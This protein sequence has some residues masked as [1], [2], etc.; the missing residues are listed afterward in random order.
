M[1]VDRV[2]GI[3]AGY[4]S[5]SHAMKANHSNI[6]GKYRVYSTTLHPPSKIIELSNEVAG[7]K[8]RKTRVSRD[9][10]VLT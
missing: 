2:E 3:E 10:P 5:G 9:I 8:D 1:F 7:R 6:Y 4:G